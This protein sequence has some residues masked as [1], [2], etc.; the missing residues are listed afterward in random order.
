[1]RNPD[2]IPQILLMLQWYWNKLPDMRLGQIISN[3]SKY[4]INSDDPFFMEDDLMWDW[5]VAEYKKDTGK[6]I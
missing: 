5:L 4:K 6:D 2:R 1:M 3:I